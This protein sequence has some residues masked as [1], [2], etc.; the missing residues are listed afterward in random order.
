MFDFCK[1]CNFTRKI[2]QLGAHYL[3]SESHTIQHNPQNM[4]ANSM[5]NSSNYTENKN[6]TL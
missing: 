4:Q 3:K 5:T 1:L 6:A 2:I